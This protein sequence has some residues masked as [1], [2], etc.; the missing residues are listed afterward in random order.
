MNNTVADKQAVAEAIQ[1]EIDALA[2]RMRLRLVGG[3]YDN[4]LSPLRVFTIEPASD[5]KLRASIDETL[6]SV[7]LN[8]LSVEHADTLLEALILMKI[9]YRG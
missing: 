2:S 5:A 9:Q 6:A 4:V 1:I 7:Q 3:G 8:G